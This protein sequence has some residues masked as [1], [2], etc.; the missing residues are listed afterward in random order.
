[1]RS[2][3]LVGAYVLI[4]LGAYFLLQKQGWL[5]NLGPLLSEWWPVILIVIG[6]TM[7]VRRRSRN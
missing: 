1:M 7:L 6:V 3:S 4:A 5:P 2:N